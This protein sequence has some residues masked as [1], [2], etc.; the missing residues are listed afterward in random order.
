MSNPPPAVQSG[1]R[2]P[3]PV[4]AP[5]EPDSE[6]EF[7]DQGENVIAYL[8]FQP[9]WANTLLEIVTTNPFIMAKNQAGKV[10]H[11]LPTGELLG[12]DCD[13]IP[14]PEDFPIRII[15]DVRT[16]DQPPQSEPAPQDAQQ[17]GE[18]R[19]GLD[20]VK[21]VLNPYHPA[22]DITMQLDD[23]N[24]NNFDQTEEL[25]SATTSPQVFG[26]PSQQQGLVRN[27]PSS[28]TQAAPPKNTN[29]VRSSPT[30]TSTT[31]PMYATPIV[32]GNINFCVYPHAGHCSHMRTDELALTWSKPLTNVP[33][34]A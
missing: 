7:N 28:K 15:K 22:S 6:P 3:F 16:P 10:W 12:Q 11:I 17:C 14:A 20:Y 23:P 29:T 1:P 4:Q 30:T 18:P 8:M 25:L 9:D 32:T 21:P 24:S 34:S 31:P 33:R 27:K 5:D 2:L 26:P 19:R 13:D